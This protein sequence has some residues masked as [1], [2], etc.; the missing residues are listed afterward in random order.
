M[1]AAGLAALRACESNGNYGA[2]SSNGLYKGAY[3]FHQRT[4]NDVASRHYPHLVG[5]NPAAASAAA[6][7]AMARALWGEAGRSPWPVCGKRV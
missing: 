1:S 7:D 2:V 6:Q 4:W 5:V 3:Q